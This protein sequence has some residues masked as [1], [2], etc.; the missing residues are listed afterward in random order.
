MKVSTLVGWSEANTPREAR[1]A[2][3][4]GT[5]FEK[6]SNSKLGC[7][8][9]TRRCKIPNAVPMTHSFHW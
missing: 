3:N 4:S 6:I 5:V 8:R 9:Q 7:D 1:P 2:K